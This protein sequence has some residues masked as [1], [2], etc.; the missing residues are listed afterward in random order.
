DHE[1]A[2]WLIGATTLFR[3]S[4]LALSLAPV[5]A[6]IDFRWF[7]SPD[8]GPAAI[9][10]ALLLLSIVPA[11]YA[12][13]VNA[14]L[15]GFERM[16]VAAWINIGISLIRAPLAILLGATTLG[17]AGVALAALITATASAYAF[18]AA[19]RAF[20]RSPVRWT[21]DRGSARTL[22]RESWPL[23]INAL[24]VSLFFRVDIF[25]VDAL[26]GSRE[27]GIYDAAYKFINLL[28]IIP[29]YATLAVFPLMVQRTDDLAGFIRAQR[30]TTYL[31]VLLG[32]I[33]VALMTPLAGFA[34]LV[35]AGNE[36]LPESATLLRILIW[37][38]P[39]SFLNGVYQY[40]L[41]ARGA[42]RKIVPVFL[43]AFAFNVAANA[44]L[45]PLFGATAAAFNTVA[46]EVVIFAAFA[47]TARRDD[48][49]IFA[50]GVFR[51][52]WRPTAAGLVAVVGSY[53][54]L[55]NE[56]LAVAYATLAFIVI[57]LVLNVISDEEI[58]IFRR[59]LGR[60]APSPAAH[61]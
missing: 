48:V 22:A 30:I 41:I 49:T 51:R 17:V 14:A 37:F 33:V 58:R 61:S 43:S 15:N 31:L 11:S 44:G 16:E 4:I 29:A 35:L 57:S 53:L 27:L 38:A 28:T 20:D 50:G 10:T 9:A 12:E 13:A 59:I 8:T 7:Q 47:W 34:M 18:H 32:W 1:R 21:L 39:I 46:T 19:F 40:V 3:W 52:L 6:Y 26:H 56:W 55:P 54:L 36:Y 23:L 42:Q 24:L 5:S 45:V 60:G 25:I 2:G